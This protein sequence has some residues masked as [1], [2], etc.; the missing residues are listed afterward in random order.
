MWPVQVPIRSAGCQTG[1]SEDES[2]AESDLRHRTA[3]VGSGNHQT[4][5]ASKL[6]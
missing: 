2:C 1:P 4:Q 3:P 6:S 5:N